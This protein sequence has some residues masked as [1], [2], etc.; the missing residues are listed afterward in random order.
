[1]LKH[2]K[3]KSDVVRLALFLASRPLDMN[4][5]QEASGVSNPLAY[6]KKEDVI[7]SK[8]GRYSLEAGARSYVLNKL[9]P[10]LRSNDDS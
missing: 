2:P 7:R 10:A 1:M 3:K 8:E 9:I 5:W 4:Q 6:V